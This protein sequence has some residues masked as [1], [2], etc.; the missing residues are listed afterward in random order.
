MLLALFLVAYVALSVSLIPFDFRDLCYLFSLEQGRWVMQEWVHPIYVPLLD[1]LRTG[2]GLVGYDGRM[3]VPVE[4][5]NV[6]AATL[7]LV[8]LYR[9]ARRFPGASLA[10][11]VAVGMTAL[12]N[13]F[14]PATVR[15][16]PYALACLF[17]ALALLL[18]VS[19]TPVP[20]RRYAL[21]G[22][23]AGVAMGLHASAMA[24]GVVAVVCALFEP[25]PA[26]TSRVTFVRVASF[27]GG[28]L[29]SAIACWAVFVWYRDI[30]VGF[31]RDQDFRTTFLAIEQ[32]PGS[33][34]YT[35][36]SVGRQLSAYA[37]YLRWQA[38]GVLPAAVV[39][40]LVAAVRR[41]RAGSAL[42]PLERRLLIAAA[43]NFAAFAGFFLINNNHN[44]F[45]YAALT[46]VPVVLAVAV[47]NSPILLALLVVLA[48]PEAFRN[49]GDMRSGPKGRNDPLLVES[50]FLQRLL[51]PRD[52]LLTPGT[53]FPEALYLSHLNVL[54]VSDGA[55]SHPSPE[56]PVVRPG[57]E[58]RARIAWWLGHGGHVY[59]A[60]GDE[61]TDFEGDVSG[62]EKV[63]QVFWR[64]ETDARERAPRMQALRAGLEAAGIE[65]RDG[66]TSPN[67]QR[68]AEIRSGESPP[69]L[70][71]LAPPASSLPPDELSILFLEDHGDVAAPFRAHRAQ[72]LARLEAAI[73]DDPW[74][75]CDVMQLVC[76][77]RPQ[78]G[79]QPVPCAL[80]ARC[81]DLSGGR[82]GEPAVGA[83]PRPP[84][85][86]QQSAPDTCFWGALS[87]QAEESAVG[88][89]LASWARQHD[90]GRVTDW[91]FRANGQSAEMTIALSGGTLGLSW[92]LSDSCAPGPVGARPSDGIRL[93]ALSSDQLRQLVADLPVP[94]VRA[95]RAP[96]QR[97]ERH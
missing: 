2:L 3:L 7:T 92:E 13:G 37:G 86:E 34:I 1:L 77:G 43:A 90:L 81:A 83:A 73:R 38:S 50:R 91:K 58:L 19:E 69:P 66:V 6:A 71:P 78:R 59:Y 30:G 26:R 62:A 54:E 70:P 48:L 82:D 80:S 72:Y 31:F 94:K 64:P 46:L 24:L 27:A 85:G 33:S 10:A 11:A 5:L 35:N 75:A 22:A 47:R 97:E 63:R 44:G 87:S 68:Y 41:W 28:M 67:G 40:C 65:L 95:A 61:S 56:V 21:S 9:L 74:L 39:L 16:T 88:D 49:V 42:S 89:Y 84:M 76:E 52:V 18:L 45:I 14:W 36:S 53:P 17:Q 32:M 4:L 23:L 29:A 25:D 57:P 79:D 8:L 60:L 55:A 93:D 51:G 12:S 15:P 96:D 20:P